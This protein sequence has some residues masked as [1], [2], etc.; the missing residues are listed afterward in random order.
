MKKLAIMLLAM[1]PLLAAAQTAQKNTFAQFYKNY[2]GREGYTTVVITGEMIKLMKLDTKGMAGIRDITIVTE[3]KPTAEFVEQVG[4]IVDDQSYKPITLVGNGA[5]RTA[6]YLREDPSKKGAST[7]CIILVSGEKS[8][9]AMN[10][11]GDFDIT[12]L[13]D[14][15]AI[16]TE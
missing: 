11:V 13:G 4:H 14:L 16:K 9:V 8:N 3:E 1:L 6:V 12:K 7:D 5:K 15:S 10:I 2:N